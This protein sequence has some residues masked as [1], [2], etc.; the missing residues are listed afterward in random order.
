MV[1]SEKRS[2]RSLFNFIHKIRTTLQT[3][4][5]HLCNSEIS[6]VVLEIFNMKAI[7]TLIPFFLFF[8]V[9]KTENQ[10]ILEVGGLLTIKSIL[11]HKYTPSMELTL[12]R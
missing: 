10:P 11:I 1:R 8:V 2:I 9:S 12:S 6:R 7:V 3:L 4:C 5:K